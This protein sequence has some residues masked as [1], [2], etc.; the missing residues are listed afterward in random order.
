[1]QGFL[2]HYLPS[3]LE[4]IIL[5]VAIGIVF[6]AS[7]VSLLF[8]LILLPVPLVVF[9]FSLFWKKAHR[10]FRQSWRLASKS[11]SILHDIFSGIRVVKAFGM[12]HRETERYEKAA[13]DERDMQIKSDT[14]WYT[15]M[16]V[17][18]F[19]MCFGEF[20]ILFYVG[21]GI[22]DGEMTLGEMSKYSMYASMIYGPLRM[23]SNM[24]RQIINFITSHSNISKERFTEIM[25]RTDQMAN[26]VGSV[27]D[28]HE[29]VRCG[30]I[31]AVGGIKDALAA[32][33]EMCGKA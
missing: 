31:D 5:F 17:M 4:Q 27:I 11:N 32:L 16:P 21:N 19:L 24:P 14:L 28:G 20:I 33:R 29:A 30:L 7:D 25:M 23:L 18:Q 22:L 1:V 8:L 13:A 3:L 15:L 26:D 2:V 12:E 6:I 9:G 10:L